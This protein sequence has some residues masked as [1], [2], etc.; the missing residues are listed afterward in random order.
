MLGKSSEFYVT[1][2]LTNANLSDYK[3]GRRT[4]Q[5]VIHGVDIGKW[6]ESKL[7]VGWW[8]DYRA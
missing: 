1:L 8:R 3:H 7:S 5:E 4:K 6:R 2:D